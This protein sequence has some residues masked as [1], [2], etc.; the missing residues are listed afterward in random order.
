MPVNE[1]GD[2]STSMVWQSVVVGHNPMTIRN[3]DGVFR[4]RSIAL[5][6]ASDTPHRV[7]CVVTSNLLKGGFKG[8]VWLVNP[9]RET[10][11]GVGCFQSVSNLPGV[12]DLAIVATPPSTVPTLID[13]LGRKG[14][15]AAVVITAGIRD[16]LRREMLEASGRYLLRIVGPN[17]LGVMLPLVGVDASFSHRAPLPGVL[18]FL[19]QSGALVTGIVDWASSR[20]IGFSHVISMG[21]MADVDAGDLLDYLAGDTQSHAILM[22]LENITHAPKFMSAARRAARAKPVIVIKS[23]RHAAGAAAALSHTGA[24]AGADSAYEA[25]FRRAGV[26]RVYELSELFGAAEVLARVPKLTGEALAIITNGGGAG[27]LAVDRMGDLDLDPAELSLETIASL[28]R[29]LP[30]MW[31]RRDPVDIIG[32]APAERFGAALEAVLDDPGVDAA[33]VLN[34]PT[35]LNPSLAAARAVSDVVEARRAAGKGIKPVLTA[36]LG[37]EAAAESRQHFAAHDLATFETPAAAV[38]GYSTLI[39][40]HRAQTE[41]MAT[42]MSLPEGGGDGVTRVSEIIQAALRDGR[43]VLTEVEGKAMLSAYGIATVE[44]AIAKSPREVEELAGP[45]IKNHGACAIKILSVDITHKSDVGGVRL[46]LE[47]PQQAAQAAQGMLERLRVTMP[48]ARIEGFTVQPMIKRPGAH[49]LLLGISR[50][51]TFGPLIT[52]GAGGIAVEAL[53]DVA[54]ALPPLDLNLA[55][56]MMRQTRVWRLLQGYRTRPPANI[57][58]IAAVLVRLSN[59]AADH[60]EICELDINP[61]LADDKGVIAL[62]ARVRISDATKFPCTPMAIKPY[63]SKWEAIREFGPLGSVLLRPIRPEDELL[64]SDFFALVDRDDQRMRFFTPHTSLSH[65]FLA[66]LTQIDYAREMA[67]VAISRGDGRLLGVSR[68]VADPDFVTGEFAILVRS[69]VKGH[70]LGWALMMHLITY[71]QESGLQQIYGHVMRSNTTMMAM[72]QELGFE[73]MSDPD[74]PTLNMA[75]LSIKR[76]SPQPGK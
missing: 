68:F 27:V 29:V 12:P 33:L 19:S 74:D 70:G 41:L 63:P 30:A 9:T 13:E 52:F 16:D 20:G 24:L 45:P 21:D 36:W 48:D 73:I 66:R 32:D 67:F 62:D 40:Y 49:E 35:A 39:R 43:D 15:R 76:I 56:D 64:Y 8:D 25:A 44:T 47:T 54:H 75:T 57:D 71:A 17:C 2:P 65:R 14:C 26:L 38:D 50:D 53:R 6:G 31:S 3:L 18:A 55:R 37:D 11:H 51:P 58:D 46:D 59:L 69:D 28:D 5:L 34:C 22:Y 60:Q 10:A 1:W 61:L 42:P 23:G 72:A 4:P 7:G